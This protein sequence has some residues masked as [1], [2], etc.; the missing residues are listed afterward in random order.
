MKKFSIILIIL[1]S[2]SL[3]FSQAYKKFQEKAE[4]AFNKNNL[5][6]AIKHAEKARGFAEIDEGKNSAA[7][8]NILHDLGLY[9]FYNYETEKGIS[10]LEESAQIL[11]TVIGENTM[12]Y[13]LAY[14]DLGSVYYYMQYYDKAQKVF[15]VTVKIAQELI[16]PNSVDAAYEYNKLGLAEL[17]LASFSEAKANLEKCRIIFEKN[18]M[19]K[20][21]EYASILN[22]LA[23]LYH[24]QK[25]YTMAE[26]Y[27]KAAIKAFEKTT[28]YSNYDFISCV[29][30]YGN[31]MSETFRY[32]EAM[33]VFDKIEPEIITYFGMESLEY[34]KLINE[35]GAIHNKNG[36]FSMAE[37]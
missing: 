10:H 17:A 7:Y 25:Q 19:D 15:I 18:G 26:K 22:N 11:Q 33:K 36:N 21:V 24:D 14:S 8:A 16:G 6:E 32:D 34:A 30:N 20:S 37:K 27:Y 12:D 9:Y 13:M 2:N 5:E 3:L 1:F 29:Q 4:E 35:K 31:F 23:N 28:D